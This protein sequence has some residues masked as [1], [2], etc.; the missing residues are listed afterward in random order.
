MFAWGLSYFTPCLH[1]CNLAVPSHPLPKSQIKI[2]G[3][4]MSDRVLAR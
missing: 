4:Q 2:L 1:F 3:K